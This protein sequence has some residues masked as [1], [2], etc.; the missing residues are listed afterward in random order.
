[1]P[2]S[3]ICEQAKPDQLPAMRLLAFS[4]RYSTIVILNIEL[5]INICGGHICEEEKLAA[6]L[7][8]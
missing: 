8:T 4:S 3:D 1:M 7:H 6:G 2:G 5:M